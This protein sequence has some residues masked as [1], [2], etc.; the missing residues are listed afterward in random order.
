MKNIYKL[1]LLLAAVF[2]VSNAQ[3]QV[4]YEQYRDPVSEGRRLEV[5]GVDLL[6]VDQFQTIGGDTITDFN[7]NLNADYRQWKFDS[8]V[9]VG[10]YF[11]TGVNYN[12]LKV[13]SGNSVGRTDFAALGFGGASYYFTPNQIYI[14]GAL[15]LSYQRFNQDTGT[16]GSISDYEGPGYLWGALGYG[17]LYNAGTITT[18]KDVEEAL[19]R[20]GVMNSTSRFSNTVTLGIANLLKKRAYGD[21]DTKNHDDQDIAFFTDLQSLLQKEGVVSGPLTMAQ[22]IRVYEAINNTR[23][24]YVRYPRYTGIQAQ[25]QAQY[26]LFNQTKNK[27]HDHYLSFDAVFGKPLSDQTQLLLSGFFAMALDSLASGL[28]PAA[29][30]GGPFSFPSFLPFIPD[31]NNLDFFVRTNGTGL[32]GGSYVGGKDK[33]FGARADIT[34]SINSRAGI[35]G[36]ASFINLSP[37]TGDSRTLIS[38]GARLDYN[39]THWLTSYIR[40]GFDKETDRVLVYSIGAGFNWRVFGNN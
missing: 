29:G 17:R 1:V 8:R 14:T 38:G 35:S 21:Y 18:A 3:S 12:S 15:G 33:L 26:Q 5:Y 13:N 10:G 9:L 40:A 16:S 27:P 2:V 32:Y 34:H 30:F 28:G 6:S 24:R 20:G 7:L 25:I 23:G 11:A 4:L 36:F 22:T 37:N 39:L 31:R 19:V